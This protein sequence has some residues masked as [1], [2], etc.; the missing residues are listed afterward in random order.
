MQS[1]TTFD[2]REA[3][4]AIFKPAIFGKIFR[5]ALNE[6]TDPSRTQGFWDCCPR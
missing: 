2:H 3:N 1:S 6:I 5:V 4:P